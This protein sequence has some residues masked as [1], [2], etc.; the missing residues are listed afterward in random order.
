MKFQFEV[1]KAVADAYAVLSARPEFFGLSPKQLIGI[2]I[3]REVSGASNQGSGVA[4]QVIVPKI[5]MKEQKAA[6]RA[7][8][9]EEELAGYRATGEWPV[10]HGLVQGDEVW[11]PFGTTVRSLNRPIEFAPPEDY[12]QM[13]EYKRKLAKDQGNADPTEPRP[14]DYTNMEE[15]D[16][17]YH[18]WGLEQRR[19]CV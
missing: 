10:F 17:A 5:T 11:M 8:K 9:R 19:G 2:L 15:F 4:R 3:M 12:P 18:A 7:Q 13:A 6:D 16:E 1:V 14:K